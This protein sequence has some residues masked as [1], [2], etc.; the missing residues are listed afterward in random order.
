MTTH[1]ERDVAKTEQGEGASPEQKAIEGEKK[2]H[3]RR[4]R[5]RRRFHK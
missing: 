5:H 4:R 2:F 3:K 1:K